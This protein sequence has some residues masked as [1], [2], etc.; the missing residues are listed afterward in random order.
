VVSL[1]QELRA[2]ELQ[3]LLDMSRELLVIFELDGG[4]R[5]LS[6]A[7]DT[8]LGGDRGTLDTANIAALVHP[9]DRD[10]LGPEI[11]DRMAA[12]H[13]QGEFVVR[14]LHQ[15]G[16]ERR[17]DW[18]W[19]LDKPSSVFLAIGRDVTSEFEARVDLE[20]A[21]GRIQSLIGRMSDP[22]M[23]IDRDGR[24]VYINDA[25]VQ[26]FG[27]PRE[28][29]IGRSL[30]DDF[31]V[32]GT[33]FEAEYRAALEDGEPRLF[34]EFSAETG[35][36]IEVRAMPDAEGLGI[37][38]R[39]VTERHDLESQLHQSQKME[40]IGRL[41]GG[42]AHDFN[43]LLTAIMGYSEI[44][45]HDGLA[46]ADRLSVSAIRR[47]ADRAAIL[48][49]QLLAFGR[50]QILDF[51]VLDADEV[52][53]GI[54]SLFDR[55][56]GE[57]VTLQISPSPEPA[58]IKA[59]ASQLEQ[60]LVNLVVN[61]RDAMPTGGT[62]TIEVAPVELD[63]S[64]A[65]SHVEVTPGP[66]VMIAVSDTGTGMS[67]EVQAQV[68]EP[69]FTTK[70]TGLGTGLGLST[71]F[72]IVKQSGG[73]IGVYS[74]VGRGS[75]FKVYLPRVF[76]AAD[77]PDVREPTAINLEGTETVL[78]AEDDESVREI[79]IMAL[80][81]HGYEVLVATSGEEAVSLAADHPGP[82]HLLV[83]DVVMRGMT[84][85]DLSDALVLERPLVRTLYVSGYTENTIVHHGVL[86]S[87]IAFLA[88]PFTPIGL[89][90]RVRE[91]LEA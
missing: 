64:Y 61:A 89:A 77:L 21:E 4:I 69:F 53:A 31:G 63:E 72:G 38:Y 78:L 46:D 12:G 7:W 81:R 3:R 62:I 29:L 70:A 34:E 82:I 14:M 75:V 17:I 19:R 85:R 60:I 16:T 27:R 48:T 11:Q 28:E 59:D 80:R 47:A 52:V 2:E 5:Y 88:K 6:P 37:T 30:W 76:V 79:T 55:L 83:T 68:F 90:R 56:V 49:R 66:H 26:R 54:S 71:V 1:D 57:D 74:E 50:R 10:R 67:P 40:A 15:D 42:V 91:V 9:D 84:G 51:R 44:L 35:R 20:G 41:A 73:S 87:G 22:S 45:D 33:R 58:R 43:N 24:L 36:W 86:E 13:D 65:R 39:D 18:I 8:V 32:A 23:G 25:A